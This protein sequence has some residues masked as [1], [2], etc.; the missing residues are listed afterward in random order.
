[1][2]SVFSLVLCCGFTSLNQPSAGK[3]GPLSEEQ[4]YQQER[5]QMVDTQIQARGVKDPGV[6]RAMLKVPRHLYVPQRLKTHAYED[7][8][9]PIEN[10]QTIS[11]PYIVAL[12]TELAQLKP[13]DKVLEIGTGSGY[14][15]AVLAEIVKDVYT[16]EIIGEL[17][18]QAKKRLDSLGYKNIHIRHG[19][20]YL[21]WPEHAPFDAIIVT[22]A[23]KDIPQ[24]LVRQLKTG[25]R[26]VIPLGSLYQDLYVITKREDGT[27]EKRHVIP[28]RFVPMVGNN[29]KNE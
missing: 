22:A 23:P 16:I 24:E 5:K 20:G 19:N 15:A 11:Q 7:N 3:S 27:I 26:M 8:A 29:E 12:M 28:V 25:G 10:N 6:L 9:L 18:E 17:A 4:K 14:Q 2:F 13:D 1:M 21:G